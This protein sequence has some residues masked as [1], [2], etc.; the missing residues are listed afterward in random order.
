MNPHHHSENLSCLFAIIH[1]V[2]LTVL[3]ALGNKW[4][5]HAVAASMGYPEYPWISLRFQCFRIRQHIV[6]KSGNIL[7]IL[8]MMSWPLFE[9]WMMRHIIYECPL[10]RM[11]TRGLVQPVACFS[12]EERL[13]GEAGQSLGKDGI[14][15]QSVHHQQRRKHLCLLKMVTNPGS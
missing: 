7:W 13:R 15:C 5:C 6:T 14:S 10:S 3:M 9:T 8:S 2:T 4:T 11:D 12:W 1:A